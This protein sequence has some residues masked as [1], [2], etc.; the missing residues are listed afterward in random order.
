MK[1]NAPASI[2]RRLNTIQLFVSHRNPNFAGTAVFPWD[3]RVD[4]WDSL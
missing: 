1:E 4:N 2:L 3:Y